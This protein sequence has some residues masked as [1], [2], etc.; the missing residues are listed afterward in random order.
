MR[1]LLAEDDP[2]IAG[3]LVQ[4]LVED[5]H[6]VEHV[7]DGPTA[8]AFA[9][10]G[11]FDVVLLDLGLPGLDGMDVLRS[12]RAEEAGPAVIVMTARGRL[13]EKVAGLDAGADDYL[14]KPFAY[15]ELRARLRAV[16]R[17]GTA[18]TS[19]VLR[20]G[21]I[22]LDESAAT[23]TGPGGEVVPLTRRELALLRALMMHPGMVLSRGQLE[24][25]VYEGEVEIESNAIDFLIRRLRGKLGPESI[26]NVRG[27]GWT[28]PRLP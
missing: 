3:V 6:V 13:E 26:R 10:L 14:T 27:L 11:D 1:I 16:G 5:A 22:T 21:G 4:R 25:Q 7:D 17:R 24:A 19:A 23:A 28:I 8:A 9:P 2:M 18:H 12:L 20:A 15:E